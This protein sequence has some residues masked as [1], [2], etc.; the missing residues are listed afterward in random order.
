MRS[1]SPTSTLSMVGSLSP[2]CLTSSSVISRTQSNRCRCKL[3]PAI[4]TDC[5]GAFTTSRVEEWIR[6]NGCVPHKS[7]SNSLRTSIAADM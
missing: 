4:L 3:P 7:R 1:N 2:T 5:H 6:S